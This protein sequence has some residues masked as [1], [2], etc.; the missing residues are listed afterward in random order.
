MAS[1]GGFLWFLGFLLLMFFAFQAVGGAAG[2][3][4]SCLAGGSSSTGWWSCWPEVL[5]AVEALQPDSRVQPV[6]TPRHSSDCKTAEDKNF[7]KLTGN[8]A[9]LHTK[10]IL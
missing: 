6:P 3:S 5:M 7:T 4:P 8:D 2:G 9:H 10:Q 1:D